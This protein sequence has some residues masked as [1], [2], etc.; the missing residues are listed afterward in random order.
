MR[1]YQELEPPLFSHSPV[2]LSVRD[3]AELFTHQ[4]QKKTKEVV[5]MWH[6]T[7]LQRSLSLCAAALV[8]LFTVSTGAMAAT[9]QNITL[10]P[11]WN[12]V[13]LEV[14][15]EVRTPAEVFK[16]LPVESVWTWFDR[17][18]SVEF[19]RDPSE[20]LWA[21]LGWSVYTRAPD[22]A[23]AI[24]L[25]AILANRAYLIKL[26]GTQDVAWS[27][28]GTP[29]TGK[30]IWNATSFNLVGFHVNPASQPT[31]DTY[32]SLSPAL[33]GQPVYRLNSFGKWELIANPSTTKIKSGEAYWIYCN[34]PSSYQGPLTVQILGGALDFGTT[35]YKNSVTLTNDSVATRT[36]NITYQ[37]AADW[38]TYESFNVTSG[39]YE[40]LQLSSL[41]RQ[42]SAG[43]QINI[44]FAVRRELLTNGLFQGTL[45]IT[46]DVGSRLLIPVRVEKQVP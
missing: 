3:L 33:K 26:G 6:C 5:Q 8:I 23:A 30:T 10:R 12:A 1:D 13:Y 46:D 45:E 31:F 37:P 35:L 16:N 19:I 40:Y 36:V 11:G 18:S 32:L 7:V 29:A 27:I 34:V 22:K 42:I 44:W 28:T 2:W 4:Q 21:E 41:S 24:N 9:T 38:F 43:R 14:Q 39:F 17:T 25:F 15:P 20:G